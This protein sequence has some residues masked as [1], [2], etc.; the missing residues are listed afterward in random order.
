MRDARTVSP[1]ADGA[2]PALGAGPAGESLL[3]PPTHPI[4]RAQPGPPLGQDARRRR[5]HGRIGGVF[6]GDGGALLAALGNR[7]GPGSALLRA[8]DLAGPRLVADWDACTLDGRPL[9]DLAAW[10]AAVD[11][12]RLAEVQG[13]FCLAWLDSQGALCL[14]RDAI[15]H[16][17]LFYAPVAG[18][19]VFASTIHAVLAALTAG[20]GAARLNLSGLSRYLSCAYLP[21]RQTLAE[22]VCKLLPGELLR[23]A[24]SQPGAAPTSRP[25]VRLPPEPQPAEQ[26]D[27][28][29]LRERLRATLDETIRDLLPADDAT[30]VGA[31]LS[32]GIDSSLVVALCQRQLGGR[33]QTF[34]L[35]FGPE[36]KNELPFSSLVAEHCRTQHRVIE[37]SP[38]VVLAHLDQTIGL[39]SD[40]NGD[41]LTVPNALCFREAAEHV[42]IVLNGEGGDPCFGGPKNVPMLLAELLGD[43]GSP[44]ADEARARAGSYLRAHQKCYEELSD[45]LVPDAFSASEVAAL[46][47]EVAAHWQD[48]RWHS[49]VG[50]LMALN[51][52]WKGAHHILPKVDELSAPFGVLPRSPLFDRRLVELAFAI[53]AGLKLRGSVEKYL[54]KQAVADVVPASICERPKS[55]MLVP[56]E[57]WFSG[58]LLPVAR[59]RLLDGLRPYHLFRPAYL[60]RLLD[61]RLPGL[62]PRRGVKIWL[63][64]TLEAWLRQVLSPTLSETQSRGSP[65]VGPKVAGDRMEAMADPSQKSQDAQVLKRAIQLAERDRDQADALLHKQVLSE[66]AEELGVPAHYVD[67]AAAQLAREQERALATRRKALRI[68][69]G[70][71][72]ALGAVLGAQV[73]LRPKPPVHYSM[74]G[75]DW[76]LHKNPETAAS[77]RFASLD[78]REAAVVQVERF[79]KDAAGKYHVNLDASMALPKVEDHRSVV[80]STR[81]QGLSQ[82]RL[83]LEVGPQERYRSPPVTL[84]PQWVE[85]RLPLSLFEHQRRDGEAWQRAAAKSPHGIERLSFKLGHFMNEETA[86]GEAAVAG[87]RFE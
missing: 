70:A 34:S 17:S 25:L 68:G 32:G 71:T 56:V 37:L 4:V 2:L 39:L 44:D 14:A 42:G 74:R 69:I 64:L 76:G 84:T 19:L 20:G 45:L 30:P 83:F 6:G 63:L 43:G 52:V 24:R 62:R 35:S 48:R 67:Q 60:E 86:T 87:L 49:F 11:G 80:F 28:D 3:S 36:Y 9:V 77:L 57:G 38:A 31:T 5:P 41:P 13:A 81:G 82:V 7:L 79:G 53:P 73:L 40:P 26:Q 55:G 29:T 61:G 21:G 66:A 65:E 46:E 54:L 75:G 72:V 58:P 85:H 47:A 10:R 27:E 16:R 33:L 51:V 12:D 59:E 18:G 15:G 78:G 50:R 1:R 8:E 23:F 22:G